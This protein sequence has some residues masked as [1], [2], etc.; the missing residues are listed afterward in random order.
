MGFIDQAVD[1]LKGQANKLLGKDI[2]STG[3]AAG[4]GK[5]LYD[6]AKSQKLFGKSEGQ[7]WN[8]VGADWYKVFPYVFAVEVGGA[9]KYF[10]TLPIPPQTLVTKMIP[11]S[12]ATATFGGVVE[13]TSDNVFWIIQMS[14]TTGIAVSRDGLED[15]RANRDSVANLFRK[16]LETTGLLSGVSAQANA[17]IG[18]IG[19][20]ADAVMGSVKAFGSGDIGAG[21]AGVTGAINNAILPPQMFN[22]SGVDETTNG[23]T[24]MQEFHRFL[25]TYSHLKS[26]LP[27]DFAL[28]FQNHK[29]G[30]EWRVVVQD[31][32]VNQSASNPLLQKYSI[33]LKA[34]D[35][36]PIDS[37][38]RKEV[39]RF[40]PGGDLS[41]VNTVGAKGAADAFKGLAKNLVKSAPNSVVSKFL[42]HI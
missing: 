9:K 42:K 14:G 31:F 41:S 6:E 11:A 26:K 1:T 15:P 8:Y 23:F 7:P 10:Y 21:I 29:T 18:K 12:Q 4:K 24:E 34:W 22:G 39:D 37:E 17:L 38:S 5:N 28:K 2:F 32:T 27:K 35:V 16:K 3:T 30:Q 13:E 33:Q 40:A 36:T 20:T 19:G 25:Y